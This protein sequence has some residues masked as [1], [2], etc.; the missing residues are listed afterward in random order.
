MSEDA[1]TEIAEQQPQPVDVMNTEGQQ[2]EGLGIHHKQRSKLSCEE[3][4]KI[5]LWLLNLAKEGKLQH[6][7]IKRA[8][9][10]WKVTKVY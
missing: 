6:G 5:L 3:K 1:A 8:T 10:E 7:A 9:K 2:H 4:M